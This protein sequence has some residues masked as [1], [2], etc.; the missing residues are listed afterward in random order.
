MK[1][2]IWFLSV[3][4]LAGAAPALADVLIYQ[5]RSSSKN[6]GEGVEFSSSTRGYIVWNLEANHLTWITYSS[7]GADKYYSVS[8]GDPL[9]VSVAGA[10]GH[11]FTTF[12][13]ASG[14]GGR[15]FLDFNRGLNQALKHR[16]GQTTLFPRT[17]K[18]QSHS[19]V[20]SI[21][22]RLSE[23]TQTIVYSPK[24]TIAANDTGQTDD[25]II[26]GLRAELEARG[27]AD[28]SAARALSP[29]STATV[30]DM[31]RFQSLVPPA[32]TSLASP[33]SAR[34]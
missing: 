16:T 5:F 22:P 26:S 32:R 4:V 17:F 19:I 6:I 13:G 33:A 25:A 1:Q 14:T 9:V 34:K 7:R 8:D 29:G 30:S 24:R 3:M 31:V 2:L 21:G 23:Y 18:G 28:L 10:S 11:Q 27:Y 12:S 20:T 15:Y